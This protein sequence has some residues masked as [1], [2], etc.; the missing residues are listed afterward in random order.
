MTLLS[1]IPAYLA[2][3][4][5]EYKPGSFSDSDFWWLVQSSAMGLLALLT[6]S[7]PIWEGSK[8]PSQNWFWTWTFIIIAAI[9]TVSAVPLYILAPVAYSSSL[10]FV[11][12]VAQAF[13]VLQLALAASVVMKP[14][15]GKVL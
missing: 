9:S 14:V 1:C 2:W 6:L 11:A 8:L 4:R 13:V 5:S 7:V 12:T 10:V 15:K 3:Q